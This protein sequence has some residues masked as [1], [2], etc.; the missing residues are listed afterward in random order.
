MPLPWFQRLVG[1][2]RPSAQR[3]QSE[4][5]VVDDQAEVRVVLQDMLERLGW[6]V[7]TAGGP[8]EAL[9][10]L[11]ERADAIGLALIDVMMP[12]CDG[13]SLALRLRQIHPSLAV[14]LL[15]GMLK[16]E[17][18]WVISEQGFRF[19]PKPFA[20]AELRA[21]VTEVMGEARP[22]GPRE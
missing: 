14:V 9:G 12:D 17:T 13:V 19:L 11:A 1:T 16:E 6:S 4:I 18:R 22:G 20:L 7:R 8:D 2:S 15:S 21:V 10:I 3:T 5:L